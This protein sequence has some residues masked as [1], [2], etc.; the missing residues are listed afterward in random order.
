MKY[1]AMALVGCL[2]TL[3]TLSGLADDVDIA[4]ENDRSDLPRWA[5]GHLTPFHDGLSEW[6]NTGSRSLDGFFG[7]TDALTVENDSYLRLKYEAEW[8]EG[9]GNDHDFGARF[10]LDLPT[11]EERLRLVIENEP[12]EYRGTLAGQETSLADDDNDGLS[13]LLVGIKRLGNHDKRKRW[14][15]QLGAG[16]KLRLP[17]VPYVRATTQRLWTLDDGPWQLH[18]DNRASWFNRDGYSV[19]T[20]WD[21]GRPLDEQRHFR[22]L[23]NLQWREEQDTLEYSQAAELNRRLNRRSVLR[24][25]GVLLGESASS[26]AIEDSYLEVR[27]RRDIHKG[28][29]FLDIAPSL[30]FAREDD[31]EPRWALNLSLEMYFRR[32]IDR[33]SL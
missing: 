18:S 10:R 30:H 32:H 26:P 20:R 2:A 13:G 17:P 28:Y 4:N 9:R 22:L 16:V 11:T 7:S 23:S 15:T 33:V 24:Y 3:I 6:V 31:R 5:S 12:E 21:L 14:N 19:R 1:L 27:Y 29:T 25:S 8:F